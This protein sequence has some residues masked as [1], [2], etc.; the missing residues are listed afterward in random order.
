MLT[1]RRSTGC[2]LAVILF[3]LCWQPVSAG[4]TDQE[5]LSQRISFIQSRLDEGTT[6]AKRWQ[7]S[8]VVAHGTLTF[9]QFGMLDTLREPEEADDRFDMVVGGT[10]EALAIVD[11]AINPLV[12]HS[13]AAKL[14]TMPETNSAETE[15]K[16]QYAEELLWECAERERK[17][18]SWINHA[19]YF[20]GN[21][22][23]GL[24]IGLDGGR[25]NDGALMFGVG[26]ALSE[27][28]IF[29][30]PTRAIDDWKKYQ[31]MAPPDMARAL[32][33][34][35]RRISLAISPYQTGVRCAVRF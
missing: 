9:V 31:E 24:V 28:Q 14:R 17:G 12:A 15:A 8:W 23:A 7:Y 26:M 11:L 6:A 34:K 5:D 19:I 35:A 27:I 30:Q 2:L 21:A 10:L 4:A 29:T 32:P 3:S 25:W 22:I 1:G 18:R 13:A 16:A 20:A 33:R